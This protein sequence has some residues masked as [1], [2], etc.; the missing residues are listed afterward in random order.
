M[1]KIYEKLFL[2]SVNTSYVLYIIA[3]FGIGGFAPYYLEH[4]RTFLKYY[5]GLLLIF[6][7]NPITYKNR[8][9]SEFDRKVVFS[10][11]T[12]LL[13][14]TTLISGVEEYIR[15]KSQYFIQENVIGIF[16]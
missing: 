1:N 14:S 13:L 12:F 7:Y 2:Y 4:L 15:Q 11:A 3:L 5:I 16:N 8:Q 6:L 9:F 10:S